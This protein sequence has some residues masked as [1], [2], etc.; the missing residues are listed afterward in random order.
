M[1]SRGG[2]LKG[3]GVPLA[4]IKFKI[5]HPTRIRAIEKTGKH[6]MMLSG[7]G[8]MDVSPRSLSTRRAVTTKENISRP[9]NAAPTGVKKL[10]TFLLPVATL[11]RISIHPVFIDTVHRP[12]N[13]GVGAGIRLLRKN[14]V[15]RA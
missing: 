14:R 7:P 11:Y 10:R 5:D 13:V 9:K 1:T 8:I 2:G 4:L 15:K 12:G 3:T 6:K